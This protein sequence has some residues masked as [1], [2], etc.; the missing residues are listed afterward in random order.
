[1]S[2]KNKAIARRFYEEFAVQRKQSVLEELVARNMVDHN[3]PGPGFAS[4]REGVRQVFDM[5]HSAMP[6]ITLTIEDQ[7]AEGDKVVSRLTVRGTHKGELMG[8]P[9]TGKKLTMDIIDVLRLKDGKLV[10]RWGESDNMGLMQQ[11]GAVPMPVG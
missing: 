11:L 4:G 2:E 10:E 6:D 9:P 5:F 1:M 7:I 8:V 3:P